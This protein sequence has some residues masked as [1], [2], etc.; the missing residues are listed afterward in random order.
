MSFV[1]CRSLCKAV[2]DDDVSSLQKLLR[3]VHDVKIET[4]VLLSAVHLAQ[5]NCIKVLITNGCDPVFQLEGTS[6]VQCAI[7]KND[8]KTL[9]LL[10][11]QQHSLD[12]VD[13]KPVDVRSHIYRSWYAD[14][15]PVDEALF[16]A[17]GIGNVEAVK[18]LLECGSNPNCCFYYD[19]DFLVTCSVLVAACLSPL[20]HHAPD[21]AV[22]S[23][24]VIVQALVNAGADVSRRCSTG[25]TPLH[26][27][28]K[29]RLVQSLRLLVM[30]G[31]DVNAQRAND[32]K[33]PLMMAAECDLTAV[34]TLLSAGASTDTSDHEHSTALCHAV[35][36][37][38]LP[39]AEY[40]LQ[41]G[42]S[43][44][45]PVSS[46]HA[47][48]TYT[49]L[50]WATTKCNCAMVVLLL[51]WGASVHQ[52]VS[53]SSSYITAFHIALCLNAFDLLDVFLAAGFDR[54][55]AYKLVCGG[56]DNIYGKKLT[57]LLS[58][59][60]CIKL[61]HLQK[62][63]SELSQPQKLKLLCRITIRR[64]MVSLRR[65]CELPL[66]PALRSFLSFENLCIPYL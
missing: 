4:A 30:S 66:P 57:D 44:D 27:A 7:I 64:H 41:Q 36:A 49:P 40:L 13:T 59:N 23:A 60:D 19:D 61:E 5:H 14:K 1:F 2:E 42:A 32:G 11:D 10:V 55:I 52:A 51:K 53:S 9:L 35:R 26:W 12:V 16:I 28:V 3:D 18:L 58:L 31:A 8:L 54:A 43:P 37:Q 38:S 20:R 25:M 56:I 45:V 21:S 46:F 24:E 15:R 17:S 62:L 29:A 48:G 47:T 63:C 6:A 22:A 33:T 39:I 34:T 65:L 50:Y